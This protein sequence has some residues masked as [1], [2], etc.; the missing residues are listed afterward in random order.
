MPE[1]NTAPCVTKCLMATA[2]NTVEIKERQLE[3]LAPGHVR[4][5]TQYS[6]VSTGTEL[7]TIQGTHSQERPFP[8]M[9]GYIAIGHVVGLGEGVADLELGQRVLF[10][11]AHYAM[12]D[13]PQEQCRPVPDDLPGT[14]A[15][16]TP[17]LAISLRGVR[18]ARV[19]LGD[20]VAVFGQGVIG[21][22]ATH[23]AKLSGAATVIAVDP[24]AARRDVAEKMGADVAIDPASEDVTAR[25][26]EL[27]DG[28]GVNAAIE[29]TATPKVIGSLPA[30][31]RDEGRIVVLGGIHGKAE[32]D[33]YS[34]FQKSNQTMVGAGHCY[35]SDYPYDSDWANYAAIMKMMLSGMIRPAPVVTHRV[36]YTQGPEMYRM[37]IEE[38]DK[39]IGVQ[40]D[41]REA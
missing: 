31:T 34:H 21:L 2:L 3:R 28:L 41:W 17:L 18:A 20:A 16:C 32:L 23:L 1:N 7:H 39:A 8:R 14:D 40:F 37:L 4:L 15:V 24:V 26:R 29:A 5:K 13:C 36:P 35:H 19:R 25:I 12:I 33:L 22:F 10:S 38:K 30:V 27:T 9:T 11:L 6:M